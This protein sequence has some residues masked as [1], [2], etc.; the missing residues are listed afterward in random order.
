[1]KKRFKIGHAE[2]LPTGRILRFARWHADAVSAANKCGH[3]R[4]SRQTNLGASPSASLTASFDANRVAS[5][6]LRRK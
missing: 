1:M 5:L 3:I 6:M 2:P 4:A